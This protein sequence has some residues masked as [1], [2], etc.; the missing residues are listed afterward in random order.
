MALFIWKLI[1]WLVKKVSQVKPIKITFKEKK[2]VVFFLFNPWLNNIVFSIFVMPSI[3]EDFECP[4]CILDTNVFQNRFLSF[5][6][7]LKW[8][9]KLNIKA[10]FW[11][12]FLDI[13]SK[14]SHNPWNSGNLWTNKQTNKYPRI[15]L[16]SSRTME[17][18]WV[19]TIEN[20]NRELCLEY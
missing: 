5:C 2:K 3:S 18:Y 14:F 19:N 12:I 1:L 11:H 16:E 13:C 20:Y 6:I 4:A 8:C 10:V 15:K 9:S 17:F 7:C